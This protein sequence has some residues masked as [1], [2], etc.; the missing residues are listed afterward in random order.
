MRKLSE[1]PHAIEYPA[2]QAKDV[3]K[4]KAALRACHPAGVRPS[5]RAKG[6]WIVSNSIVGYMEMAAYNIDILEQFSA[7]NDLKVRWA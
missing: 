5:W 2:F 1:W 4:T 3:P 6:E 7:G